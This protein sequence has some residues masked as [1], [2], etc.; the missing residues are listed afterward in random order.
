MATK[1]KGMIDYSRETKEIVFHMRLSPNDLAALAR[2][3]EAYGCN[4]ATAFRLGLDR[5]L[6]ELQK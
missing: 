1:V 6:R 3:E 2:I 5:L 4:R